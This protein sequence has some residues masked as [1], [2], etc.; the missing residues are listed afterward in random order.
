MEDKLIEIYKHFGYKEQLKHLHEEVYEFT[1]A[2]LLN[3]NKYHLEEEIA[4][5]LVMVNQFVEGEEL[6]KE[7]IIIHYKDS[8]KG[9]Y[10]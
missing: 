3:D 10:I 7:N 9:V 8:K 6:D 4:D 2:L 5:I 1:E